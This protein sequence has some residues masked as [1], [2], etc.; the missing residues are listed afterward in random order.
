M[1]LTLGGF[2]SRPDVKATASATGLRYNDVT[3]G[4][5]S[6]KA[7]LGPDGR[8][9]VDQLSLLNGD[10]HI[11]GSGYID[12]F[13]SGFNLNEKGTLSAEMAFTQCRPEAFYGKVPV[14]GLMEGAIS[15]SGS[16]TAPLG[17]IALS[18]NQ[19]AY[20]ENPI[21]DMTVTAHYGHGEGTLHR[22]ALRNGASQLTLSGRARFLDTDTRTLVANPDVRL[23]VDESTI[24]LADFKKEL[25][26]KMRISGIL[27]GNV[28]NPTGTLEIQGESLNLNVQ[29]INRFALR[30]GLA[31]QM[32]KVSDCTIHLDEDHPIMAAGTLSLSPD[33]PFELAVHAID[34]PLSVVG[35]ISHTDLSGNVSV[36]VSGKGS[37]KAPALKASAIHQKF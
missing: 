20:G 36:T 32:L 15:L 1:N 16:M 13:T 9:S 23:R 28:N 24:F 12:L 37:I 30:V 22:L 3:L 26:G 7:A 35:P 25:Q 19:L 33:F 5:V 10:G 4:D 34:L 31:N 6:L 29:Q 2:L 17:D 14:K 18:G 11:T 27:E 8:L 21:G